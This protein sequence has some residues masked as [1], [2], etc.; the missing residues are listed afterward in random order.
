MVCM[1]VCV[2]TLISGRD[3]FFISIAHILQYLD[4]TH[5]RTHMKYMAQAKIESGP[6]R[7]FAPMGTEWQSVH[8]QHKREHNV[9]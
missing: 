7:A 2:Y 4:N 5:A 8:N 6:S 3:E 9:A 1:C